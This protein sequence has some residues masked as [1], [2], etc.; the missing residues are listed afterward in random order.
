M[1]QAWRIVK[2]KWVATAFD[3][4]GARRSG[5]RWNSPGTRLVYTS[6]TQS[7]ATLEVLVHLEDEGLLH[8]Y[9]V[10]PVDFEDDLVQTVSLADLPSQW[11]ETQA[12]GHTRKIGD[13]WVKQQKSVLLC[14]PSSIVPNERNYLINPAHPDF[15]AVQ[16][17][18]AQPFPFDSRL[19]KVASS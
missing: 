15:K 11:N 9:S 5:G 1:G 16:I 10:M 7:L 18:E 12:I 2:T 4:E 6:A 8:R 13:L 14:V 3:G 17:G 19:F